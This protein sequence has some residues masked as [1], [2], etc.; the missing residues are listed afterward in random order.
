VLGSEGR[1]GIITQ[2]VVRVRPIPETEAF[3]GVFFKSWEAGVTAVRT[4]VQNGLA[5]SMLR[6]SDPLE[7]EIT[8]RLAG[9][10]RLVAWAERGLALLGL[11]P[12]RCL[13]IYGLTGP[14]RIAARTQRQ[15][16][17]CWRAFGGLFTGPFIGQ[18]W[19]QSRFRTPYL[20]NTLWE[21]GLALDTLET[22]VS[23]RVARAA[24]QSITTDL[25]AAL[26]EVGERALVFCHLSHLYPDGVSIY[27][28]YLFHRTADP[29][30]L[31]ERW[32][33]MKA[34]A[35]RTIQTYGGTISHHHGIGKDHAPYLPAENSVLG[36]DLLQS[37]MQTVDPANLMNPGTLLAAEELE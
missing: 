20:R 18:A 9:R 19:Q 7:T 24:A 22:A 14:R 12:D 32:H 31:L 26:G 15:A 34:A 33:R 29:D 36:M 3:F 4:A 21:A 1:L 25:E 23:W 37:V 13:L 30:E 16:K 2:A 8:L 27:V 6:L 35:T 17:A 10:D 28:T 11:G 5:V